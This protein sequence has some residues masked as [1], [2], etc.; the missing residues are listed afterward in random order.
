MPLADSIF[1]FLFR[2]SPRCGRRTWSRGSIAGYGS[3]AEVPGRRRSQSRQRFAR[4][5][6]SMGAHSSLRNSDFGLGIEHGAI[7]GPA[8]AELC[9]EKGPCC[10]RPS[11]RGFDRLP[12]RLW[13]R[14]P[15]ALMA[16]EFDHR[17]GWCRSC[18]PRRRARSR[19]P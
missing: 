4:A 3:T 2:M 7:S 9:S 12:N 16:R 1:V 5:P 11:R 13:A 18:R 8:V 15:L 14:G 19:C 10:G 17:L 6:W